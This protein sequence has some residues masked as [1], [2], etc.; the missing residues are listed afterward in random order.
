MGLCGQADAEGAGAVDV[1][2]ALAHLGHGLCGIRIR[3]LFPREVK[4]SFRQSGS[5]T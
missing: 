1:S 2:H 3:L 4:V 5:L